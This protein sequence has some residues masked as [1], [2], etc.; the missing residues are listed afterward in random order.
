MIRHLRALFSRQRAET[1]NDERM[2]GFYREFLRPG[3]LCFDI[4]SNM[5]NRLD[6]FR[7]LG[8]RVVAL[9]PQTACFETLRRQYAGTPEIVLLQMAAAEREGELPIYIAN[10]HTISSMSP[11][12]IDRVRGSG[13]FAEYTWATTES[14][15]CTTLD[16]LIADYGAPR[17]V[18]IDVE[19]FESQV[20]RGLS[21][22]V[23]IL[24]FEWT[25]EFFNA[26]RACLSH[27]AS[28]GKAEANYSLGESMHFA[29][30]EWV[31]F[32]ALDTAL[33]RYRHDHVVFGDI[34]VRFPEFARAHAG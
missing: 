11:E 7:R 23:P 2:L 31:A 33:D 32:P 30:D 17:F 29:L 24:S 20:L 22:P 12:W 8:C 26:T 3:D 4:G 34:Y 1:P 27:L 28:L 16:R 13:R 18:K 9:E 5:G 10:A 15:H 21:Q 19:G 6:I 14:V 25:P